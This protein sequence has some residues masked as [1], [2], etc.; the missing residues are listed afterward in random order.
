MAIRLLTP[1]IALA[2][3]MADAS[4]SARANG[5]DHDAE[6]E[7]RVRAVTAE[8]EHFTGRSIINRTYA[9]T[10]PGFAGVIPLPSSPLVEVVSLEYLDVDGATQ[11]LSEDAYVIER[12][13]EPG[14]V[15]LAAGASWPAT[16]AHP[17]A[18]ILTVI[19]GYGPDET[20]TPAAFKGFIL[21]KV[22]EYFAPAGTPESPHLIR[23]LDCLKV[24]S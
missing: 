5:A 3:S 23:G 17:Q 20:T 9:V 1:D 4:A 12:D 7:I 19:C 18:V 22:R 14:F 11:T 16:R 6:I 13:I 24:H 8:A 15:A 21:A 10:A 2:V